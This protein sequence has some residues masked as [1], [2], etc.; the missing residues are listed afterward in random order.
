MTSAGKD[1]ERRFRM[2]DS[3][4][5]FVNAEIAR[6]DFR[7]RPH[8]VTSVWGGGSGGRLYFW[9]PD[10]RSRDSR[11]LPDGTPGAYMLK[12]ASDGR[13]YLGCGRGE[14]AR[15]DPRADGFEVLVRDE[16]TSITWGGCVTDRYA[17]WSA[18][19]G[20]AGVYDHQEDRLVRIF[21]PID[22]EEPTALYGHCVVEAPDGKVILGMNVPQ[23]RLVV[24]DLDAM[25]VTSHTPPSIVGKGSTHGATFLDARTLA[26]FAGGELQLL[27]YPGFEL[28]E[29]VAP[30]EGF[31]HVGRGCLAGGRLY[32]LGPPDGSLYGLDRAGRRWELVCEAWTGGEGA[33]MSP[34][35][36]GGICAVTTGGRALRLEAHSGEQDA[37]DLEATG[38]MSAHAF[39]AVPE[40]ELIVGA[41]FINQRFWTIDLT[42]GDGRDCGRA[43]PG[44]GQVNQIVWDPVTRRVLM[45]SYTSASVTAFDPMEPPDWPR[46]PRV[47]ASAKDR[48]QMRPMALAHD[49]RHVWMA[50]SPEYGDLGG[51]LSRIDPRSGEI[52]VWR[53]IVP[54]Q[55]LNAIVLDPTRRRVYCSTEITADCGSAPP[56]QTTAELVSF[57]MDALTVRRRQPV[58]DGAPR[59]LVLALLPTNEVLAQESGDLYAWNA[60]EGR[61][62]TLGPAP[63]DLREVVRDA[64]GRLWASA[65][66]GIGRLNVKETGVSFESLIAEEGRHLQVVDDTLY[67]ACGFEVCAAPLGTAGS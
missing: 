45:S 22:T 59:V 40:V 21:R 32:A 25:T 56:T 26:L 23:A 1:L 64:K 65:E 11:R 19:P 55:K 3:R 57:D 38:P 46:N 37:F 6:V 15:Y 2:P 20:H 24:L 39:C 42:S 13:L 54:D 30:P 43:A 35:G 53:H 52:R 28:L 33:V 62:R 58:R 17:V 51:A 66:G 4:L 14:L 9:N 8:L 16:L 12:T 27:R 50:T 47:L 48:G 29:T 5:P 44:G 41:P 18:S 49:G 31:E 67:Y 63:R 61:L 7:G 60:E 36:K 10:T 34:W